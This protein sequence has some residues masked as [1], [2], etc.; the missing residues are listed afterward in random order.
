VITYDS[1]RYEASSSYLWQPSSAVWKNPPWEWGIADHWQKD[2]S[3]I[4]YGLAYGTVEAAS[5]FNSGMELPHDIVLG[6]DPEFIE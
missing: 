1:L 6:F 3:S 4:F 5:P 2:V